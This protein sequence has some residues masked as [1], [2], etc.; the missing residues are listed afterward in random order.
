[1]TCRVGFW[2]V[3]AFNSSCLGLEGASKFIALIVSVVSSIKCAKRLP[4]IV[5]VTVDTVL[6]FLA[7]SI[8]ILDLW[9]VIRQSTVMKLQIEELFVVKEGFLLAPAPSL[10]HCAVS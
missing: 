4:S 1:M 10:D 6:E 3:K 8:C 5:R 9:S 2:E 7:I